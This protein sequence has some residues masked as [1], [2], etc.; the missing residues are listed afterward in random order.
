MS[1]RHRRTVTTVYRHSPKFWP[2][3][4]KCLSGGNFALDPSHFQTHPGIWMILYMYVQHIGQVWD[5]QMKIIN[6]ESKAH[7]RKSCLCPSGAHFES[8][9]WHFRTHPGFVCVQHIC[10]VVKRVRRQ[11]WCYLIS[12]QLLTPLTIISCWRDWSSVVFQVQLSLGSNL[13]WKID[14][15]RFTFMEAAQLRHH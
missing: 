14:F 4:G 5:N 9:L 12:L 13:T 11:S 6:C 3:P 15:K 2:K 10:Q 8:D 1:D 7:T